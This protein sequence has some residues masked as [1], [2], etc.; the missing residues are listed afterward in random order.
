MR[1]LGAMSKRLLDNGFLLGLLIVSFWLLS[2]WPGY[3]NPDSALHWEEALTGRY[4]NWHPST[5]SLLVRLSQ[6]IESNYAAP[7][8]IFQA[9]LILS[10]ICFLARTVTR[11]TVTQN[12]A[13]VAFLVW[14]QTG[15]ML[16]LV[17]KDGLFAAAFMTLLGSIIRAVERGLD[18]L[19]VSAMVFASTFALA[20]LRWNGPLVVI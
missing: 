15:Y 8:V 13:V 4:P 1:Q 12:L 11:S 3:M 18:S 5:Y 20:V 17:G 6:L 14:P 7:L 16:S 19:L 9:I 10:S 2:T